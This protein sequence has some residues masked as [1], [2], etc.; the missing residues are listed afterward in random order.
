MEWQ[1]IETAPKT[2]TEI[3]LWGVMKGRTQ[4][5]KYIG[6]WFPHRDGGWWVAHGMPIR[7][8]HWMH[9]PPKPKP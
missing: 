6:S 9:L 1:D 7:P 2:P 3:L 5:W 4:R 8:T